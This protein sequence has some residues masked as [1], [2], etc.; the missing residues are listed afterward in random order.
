MSRHTIPTESADTF[1]VGW[2]APLSTY[3]A[4]KFTDPADPDDDPIEVFWLGGSPCELPT[5][6]DLE[7]ALA[8]H[9]ETLPADLA[10]QLEADRQAEGTRF[11]GRPATGLVAAAALETAGPEQAQ[12]IR[13]QLRGAL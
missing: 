2:D 6:E 7:A 4:Q 11:V 12:R 5:L 9:G 10:Q 1:A 3:F 8:Q 13:E